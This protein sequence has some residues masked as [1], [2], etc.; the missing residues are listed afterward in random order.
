M[1]NA[2]FFAVLFIFG[3]IGYLLLE[4]VWRGHSHWTMAIAGGVCL[5]LLYGVFTRIPQAALLFKC[6]IGAVII[7]AVE[8]VTGAL[9]NRWLHWDVWDYSQRRFQLYGQV[10]LTYFLLWGV[11]CVPLAFFIEAL[12][13]LR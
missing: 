8:F 12:A 7:A 5:V 6:L 10:C 13:A 9:V 2:V 3:G 4:F 1:E 11:L